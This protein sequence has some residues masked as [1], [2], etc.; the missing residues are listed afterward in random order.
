VLS[1]LLPN[2]LHPAF[3]AAG[4]VFAIAVV[5]QCFGGLG[6]N[7][8]NPALGGALFVHFSWP[9]LFYAAL[10]ASPLA[11]LEGAGVPLM[12]GGGGN[13]ITLLLTTG[14]NSG[15]LD[16]PLTDIINRFVLKPLGSQL[17]AGYVSL[18]SLSDAGIIADR[19]VLALLLGSIVIT[20]MQANRFWVSILYLG[21]YLFIV[22][23]AG[24]FSIA[25][26]SNGDMLFILFSGG[27]VLAAFF[28]LADSA[29]G[30]KTTF[31]TVLSVALC[32][33]LS[34]YFRSVKNEPYGAFFAVA[35]VN[36]LTPLVRSFE[37]RHFYDKWSTE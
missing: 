24:I 1:L 25:G 6:T 28:L 23:V 16:T 13:Q 35:C 30:A 15:L 12:P 33:V 2:T 18:F 31:G 8:L 17:P 14:W 19:A 27:T 5:K 29:V 34:W 21:I 3:A 32:A 7:W 37:S 9:A 26:T 11:L 10:E 22:R 20:V 36:V 4:S